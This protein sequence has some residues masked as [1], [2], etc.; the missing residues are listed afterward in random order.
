M[1]PRSRKGIV[2]SGNAGNSSK[3]STRSTVPEVTSSEDRPLFPPGSR[4][5]LDLLHERCQKNG[6]EET[7]RQYQPNLSYQSR[8]TKAQKKEDKVASL[9]ED[10]R[11]FSISSDL[12]R[13]PEVKMSS[14]LR[15]LVE[16]TASVFY[17]SYETAPLVLAEEEAP[18]V[19][20]RLRHLGFR[21]IQIQN[22]ISYL[23]VHTPLG[24]HLLGSLS[25]LEACIE[26]LLLHI[27]ETDLPQRFFSSNNTS[28]PFILSG[29]SGADSLK[30][31]WIEDLAIKEAGFPAHVVKEHT[32]DPNLAEDLVLLISA[33][34]R[35][36]IGKDTVALFKASANLES[37]FHGIRDR[38]DELEALGAH[39]VDSCHIV[40]PL[41]SAPVQLHVVLPP[42]TYNDR[43]LPAVYLLCAAEREDFI[44]PGEGFLIAAM[45]ALEDHWAEIET[46]GP[47]DMST[48]VGHL[49][50]PR[51]V[52]RVPDVPY[53]VPDDN[54]SR[55]TSRG[56]SRYMYDDRSDDQV[57][58]DFENVCQTRI[59]AE[60]LASRQRLP[61]FSAKDQF[62]NA[63]D[64]HRAVVVV[65][66]TGER[67]FD[68]LS[69][70]IAYSTSQV[71]QFI[72]DSLIQSGHGSKAS[73]VITQPRR[74]S[75]I[76]VAA[77]V[78]G[79]RADDGS[80]GYA[81]RGETKQDRRTKLLFCTTG[82]LLRRLGS[83]DRLEHLT[84]VVVDEVHER[85]VDGD[86][87][88]LELRELLSRH[89]TLKVVLM[90][91]TINH[92]IF[93]KYFGNAPVLTIPGFTHP[94]EDRYLE[95]FIDLLHYVPSGSR[96]G[97]KGQND[98]EY[99]DRLRSQGLSERGISSIRNI[100]AT[101]RIDY[102]LISML[103]RYIT[104]S[105]D[106]PAG[107]LIF[108]PGVQEIRQC[109]SAISSVDIEDEVD[110]YPLHA[111]LTSGEQRAVFKTSKKWKIV[112]A[113]NVAETSITIDDVV[114]V[115]DGGKVKETNYNPDTGL[116]ILTEQWITRAAARQRRGRAGR[117]KPG[118]CYK[119]YTRK[120]EGNMTPFPVPEI[121]R[122]PLESI[123]LIVKVTRENED[124]QHFLKKAIDPPNVSA[125][126]KAW[127]TL[128]ELGAVD[129]ENKLT[130]L[131]RYLA[132]LPLDLR[133]GKMLVLGLILRCLDPVLTI[134]ASLSSK[135]LFVSPL[136]KR[137]AATQARLRFD[138]H[139]SDLLTD[140]HA[141]DACV[142]LH[143]GN[144]S[145]DT[146]R[147]FCEENFISRDAIHEITSLR[148]DFFY[149]LL[150]MGL[151]A[152]LSTPDSGELNVNSTNT[153][154]IKAVILG[155]LWPRVARVYL[156]PSAIKF[157][158]VQA[159]TVQ[160]ENTAKEY[161]M[162]DPK[163]ARVFLH[164]SSVLFGESTWKSPFLAYFQ[165][166]QTTK[167]FVR[168]ATEIPIYGLLLFGGPVSVNHVGGGIVVGSVDSGTFKLKA[169][170]RIGTLVNQLRRLLEAQLEQCIEQG[171][172]LGSE[173]DLLVSN[174]ITALLDRD[175]LTSD[176]GISL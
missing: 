100:V 16:D 58:Q 34:S 39:F 128:R 173:Q 67:L 32:A 93:A 65:G 73:I 30:K 87:L 90:S 49:I 147:N 74:I 109:I 113:T 152:N 153:N 165:M 112:A 137:E 157:D 162:Y 78:S 62:L 119:L 40:M 59:Y 96:R 140:V 85:S 102:Q 122:T 28:S 14:A 105:T 52:P 42:D 89:D 43:S 11:K 164:P 25:P 99:E 15:D 127:S 53:G 9:Q 160:R 20:Q 1:A 170:P 176:R 12:T 66:E 72:L 91:A 130:A 121:L 68:F 168:G 4:Y 77:R 139:N 151:T 125:M 27:A 81:I 129:K 120:Q 64:K 55:K 63:L 126:D 114:Y 41:F 104:S 21:P 31:R 83:G 116:S 26:Y 101:D 37:S 145:R 76:S 175:G 46:N 98:K 107:I 148:Q 106:I 51:A 45:R 138:K 133:L 95:D 10:I 97:M 134:V 161:K 159:G 2:K 13:A 17:P 35:K 131:G 117:T 132:V 71:P 84:H 3:G 163:N 88:L 144:E 61:A 136:E 19:T 141:Y 60:M 111:N 24:S 115:I 108:L 146:L 80:V 75:A 94:V 92:E 54:E 142:R 50:T 171:L 118:I 56:A 7:G 8:Q 150:D 29:H 156:P 86:F 158:K 36:L 123:S 23:S 38:T 174:A 169:W 48:I 33:L 167:V 22:A 57:N 172:M 103:I 79:E 143:S 155:G 18:A 124:V 69:V 149:S 135:P 110:I 166:Q 5:P 44:E 6:W 47:P 82:V 70:V 154:V